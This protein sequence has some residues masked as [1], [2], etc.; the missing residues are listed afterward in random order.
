[1]SENL[2]LLLGTGHSLG[3]NMSDHNSAQALEPLV[4]R[5]MH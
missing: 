3:L 2:S 1:M 5:C 4:S